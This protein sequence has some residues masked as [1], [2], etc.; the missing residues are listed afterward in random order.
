MTEVPLG[1]YGVG[2]L[3][4][5]DTALREGVRERGQVHY[6]R[7]DAVLQLPCVSG[8]GRGRHDSSG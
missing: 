7:A 5:I 6:R 2:S 1:L 4:Q 3:N 8:C